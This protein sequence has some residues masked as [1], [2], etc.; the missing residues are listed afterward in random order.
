[1]GTT[2]VWR[3]RDGRPLAR[4]SLQPRL[5]IEPGHELHQDVDS[6]TG[7]EPCDGDE[8]PYGEC[9]CQCFSSW[10]NRGDLLVAVVAPK[11]GKR[12]SDA[13][14]KFDPEE[15]RVALYDWQGLDSGLSR[16]NGLIAFEG[17]GIK[18]ISACC[19]FSVNIASENIMAR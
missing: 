9:I 16:R 12:D 7:T 19:A 18:P 14:G 1:M 4:L 17:A 10:Q 8:R 3:I 5:G 13:K 2:I 11:Y 15:M 6:N